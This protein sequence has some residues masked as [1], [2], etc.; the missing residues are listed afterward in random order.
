[1]NAA[2]AVEYAIT[3][4]QKAQIESYFEG[5]KAGVQEFAHWKDGQQFVGTTGKT[6][7][8]ALEEIDQQR[9]ERLLALEKSLHSGIE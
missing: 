5:M 3:R 1:M 7:K 6:L 2:R 9:V 8:K 4:A